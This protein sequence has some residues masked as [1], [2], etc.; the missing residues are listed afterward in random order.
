MSTLVQKVKEIVIPEEK[1]KKELKK[2]LDVA[3]KMVVEMQSQQLTIKKCATYQEKILNNLQQTM[4]CSVKIGNKA[5]YM[6]TAKSAEAVGTL[7][8]NTKQMAFDE[9][10]M[11]QFTTMIRDF[12]T[13]QIEYI[14]IAKEFGQ[15]TKDFQRLGKFGKR[16]PKQIEK[17]S[18]EAA[19]NFRQVIGTFENLDSKYT[20]ITDYTLVDDE[21]RVA[22]QFEEARSRLIGKFENKD[23][24]TE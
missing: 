23:A 2:A 14:Q 6:Q 7:H 20:G 1:Q 18:A 12:Y 4:D 17:Y 13:A 9:S 11:M 10:I 8:S 3:D 19:I 5:L 15:T 24:K 16:L 22:A 21:E